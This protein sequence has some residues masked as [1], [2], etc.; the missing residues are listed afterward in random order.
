MNIST[1]RCDGSL[2]FVVEE[3]QQ[4]WHCSHRWRRSVTEVENKQ[5]QT[6]QNHVQFLLPKT[7]TQT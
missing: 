3:G 2:L 5:E 1:R 4:H 7:H 6:E